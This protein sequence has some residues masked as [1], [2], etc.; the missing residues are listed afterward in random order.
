MLDNTSKCK[1]IYANE[2]VSLQWQFPLG[3]YDDMNYVSVSEGVKLYVEDFGEGTPILLICG[4]N[5]THQSWDSQ[6]A[7]LAGSFRTI[8]FDWRGTGSSDKPRNGYNSD[9]V[10]RGPR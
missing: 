4:G 6:V 7:A 5:L 8:S 1:R 9:V 10:V 3:N 2:I